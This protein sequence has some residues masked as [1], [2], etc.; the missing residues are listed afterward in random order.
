MP[1]WCDTTWRSSAYVF[2]ATTGEMSN[3]EPYALN[4]MSWTEKAGPAGEAAVMWRDSFLEQ[5]APAGVATRRPAWWVG[6]DSVLDGAGGHTG[7][8]VALGEDED[9]RGGQ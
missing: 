2:S 6:G 3:Q 5:G 8:D 7:C 9:D 1:F 4:G